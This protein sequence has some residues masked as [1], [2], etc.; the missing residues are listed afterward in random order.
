MSY[1]IRNF[2]KRE[3][4]KKIFGNVNSGGFFITKSSAQNLFLKLDKFTR[5]SDKHT[6]NA[7]CLSLQEYGSFE[8]DDEIIF[9]N[10]DINWREE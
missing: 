6:F 10:V 5:N 7:Y 3:P 8:N 9:V 1:E 4:P 2:P